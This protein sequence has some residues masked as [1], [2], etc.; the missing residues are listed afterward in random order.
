MPA[1]A[2]HPVLE[3]WKPRAAGRTQL[4]LAAGL[5]S[6]VGAGL[7][8]VGVRWTLRAFG[9]G[10]G[11]PAA[12]LAAAAGLLKGRFVLDRAAARIADRIESRGDG[13]CAGGFLSV[14]SWLLVA[15]M[16]GAGRLLRGGLVPLKVVGPLYAAI[17][18]GLLFSSRIAW[19]RRR[20]A[21]DPRAHPRGFAP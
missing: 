8:I 1:A 20:A 4:L 11:A 14:R 13:R 21:H 6:V 2:R 17:G 19:A 7:L 15:L 16:S 18:A 12:A 3:R 5:W 9:P 10:W